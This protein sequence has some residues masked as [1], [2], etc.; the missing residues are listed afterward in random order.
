MHRTIV[1]IALGLALCLLT[2]TLGFSIATRLWP[3]RLRATVE[4][5]LSEAIQSPVSLA[6]VRANIGLGIA[7]EAFDAELWHDARGARLRIP[8][9]EARV[10]LLPLLIGRLRLSRILLDGPRL[11]IERTAEGGWEPP[12]FAAL[13]RGNGHPVASRSEVLSTRPQFADALKSDESQISHGFSKI[14]ISGD[15]VPQVSPGGDVSFRIELDI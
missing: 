15:D 7:V 6:S 9:V 8:R 11:R 12:P 5:R 10:R 1:G 4:E 13:F 2:A 3:E 14:D